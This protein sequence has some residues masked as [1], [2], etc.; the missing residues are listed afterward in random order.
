VGGAPVTLY[1]VKLRICAVYEG[2]PYLG[3]TAHPDSPRICVNGTPATG[4]FAPT[5]PTLGL[6]IGATTYYLNAG[7]DYA[8][9]VLK[10][11]YTATFTI[12]GRDLVRF[13]SDG[14]ANGGIYTAYQ[15]GANYTCPNVPGI[16]QPFAGQFLHVQVVSTE[17]MN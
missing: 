4:G 6:A 3:C 5:Y 15:G 7:N 13:I 2:R 11:D 10:L 9:K 12:R 14:G 1:K 8:D 17:P 16:T